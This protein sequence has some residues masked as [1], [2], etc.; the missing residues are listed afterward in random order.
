MSSLLSDEKVAAYLERIGASRPEKLD[1]AALRMLH[2]RHVL[3]VPF[4]T[5]DYHLGREIYH[6][7]ERAVDK[8]VYEH[9]GG[10]C[11]EVNTSFYFLLLALGFNARPHHGRVWFGDHLHGP[12]NHI[13][14]T[15]EIDGEHWIVDVGFGK[16]SRYPLLRNDGTP[17]KNRHGEF[18]VRRVDDRTTDVYRNGTPQYRFYEDEVD[19]ERDFDQ[20]VW[21]FR[22]SPD[23]PTLQNLV[24]SRPTEDGWVTLKDDV[25]ILVTGKER[26]VEKLADDGEVLAAYEKWFGFKLEQRPVPSPYVSTDPARV[27]SVEQD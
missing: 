19:L 11:G 12:Y 9:R 7:D 21:Y 4:E 2:E 18:S 22:F 23:S 27:M 5:L 1:A 20:V 16:I 15:V 3:S 8:I 10:G 13:V 26:T 14:G 6:K 24:C 25:L 17:Q